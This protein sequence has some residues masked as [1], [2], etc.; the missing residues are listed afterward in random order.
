MPTPRE[1]Q[2]ETLMSTVPCAECGHPDSPLGSH[3]CDGY[4]R[5]FYYTK[6]NVHQQMDAI[7]QL[8]ANRRPLAPD[9]I[10]GSDPR[11]FIDGKEFTFTV[12]DDS[13]DPASA[14][15]LTSPTR[16]FLDNEMW[17]IRQEF[18]VG[19]SSAVGRVTLT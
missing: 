5:E 13:S 12:G 10:Q 2:I 17:K 16:E 8:L 1:K 15:V 19:I 7:G 18:G 4:K 11:V 9:A 14:S 3:S 6:R